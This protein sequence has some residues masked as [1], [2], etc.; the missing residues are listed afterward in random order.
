ALAHRA[1]DLEIRKGRGRG[2]RRGKGLVENFD[3][4]AIADL[5]PV[6]YTR[7]QV[8]IVI[9]NCTAQPRHG[10]SASGMMTAARAPSGRRPWSRAMPDRA[11]ARG[12]KSAR[13]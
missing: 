11:S 4:D 9:E 5:R 1:D 2:F 12:L 6:R 8:H 10:R 13:G 7:R 3:I